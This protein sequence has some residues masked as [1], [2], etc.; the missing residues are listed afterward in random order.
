MQR[1]CPERQENG[2]KKEIGRCKNGFEHRVLYV[3]VCIMFELFSLILFVDSSVFF[4]FMEGIVSGIWFWPIY[5]SCMALTA[6]WMNEDGV[7]STQY[8]SFNG[9]KKRRIYWRNQNKFSNAVVVTLEQLLFISVSVRYIVCA[10]ALDECEYVIC[11][12]VVYRRCWNSLRFSLHTHSHTHSNSSSS[13]C[14]SS[15]CCATEI[16]S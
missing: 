14:S 10:I 2:E 5:L 13:A 3:C 9:K 8:T 6:H 4:L 11:T 1:P 15:S 12:C 16:S 7:W